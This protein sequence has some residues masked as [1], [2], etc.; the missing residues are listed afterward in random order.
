MDASSRSIPL[1]R[2][3]EFRPGAAL[4]FWPARILRACST[5]LRTVVL[6]RKNLPQNIPLREYLKCR[7]LDAR[8][9][10]LRL[11]VFE[12]K[13]DPDVTHRVIIKDFGLCNML[14]EVKTV[15]CNNGNVQLAPDM[16]TPVKRFALWLATYEKSRI[17]SRIASAGSAV[18][19]TL[20]QWRKTSMQHTHSIPPTHERLLDDVTLRDLEVAKHGSEV[21]EWATEFLGLNLRILQ[22]PCHGRLHCLWLAV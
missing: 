22:T 19:L 20:I 12:L 5:N 7:G 2:H 16:L 8:L 4:P 1:L 21:V 14:Q 13:P 10:C 11:G 9:E 15:V 18:Q 3:I 17:V 6:A